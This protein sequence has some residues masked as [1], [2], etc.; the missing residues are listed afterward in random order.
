ML[1]LKLFA[2][3]DEFSDKN[4][5]V[6]YGRRRNW[7]Q[8]K[9]IA[10]KGSEQMKCNL[11]LPNRTYISPRFFFFNFSHMEYEK[12]IAIAVRRQAF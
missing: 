3:V 10:S 2:K 5:S 12:Y 9:K 4:S 11:S 7:F 1:L 8:Y 6:I